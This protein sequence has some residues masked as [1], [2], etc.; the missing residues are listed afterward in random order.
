MQGLP[1][2]LWKR[3]YSSTQEFAL[4][5]RWSLRYLPAVRRDNMK[6]QQ[7]GV[8]DYFHAVS[9]C[10]RSIRFCLT[11]LL[12]YLACNCFGQTAS[13]TRPADPLQTARAF[14]NANQPIEAEKFLRDYLAHQPSSADADFLLGYAL[15]RQ[16]RAKDSLAAF[17]EG[18]RF[19]RPDAANLKIVAADYV[20]LGDF[21][22]A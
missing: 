11:I 9:K 1:G 14:L 18:A 15:F 22:D 8:V 17:T 10:E 16:Q 12:V 4:Y 5:N 21:A 7:V 19:K 6:S 2:Q 13:S 20:L 3:H